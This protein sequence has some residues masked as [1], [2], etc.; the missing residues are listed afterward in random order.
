MAKNRTQA[1]SIS[2]LVKKSTIKF[3]LFNDLPS[4]GKGLIMVYNSHF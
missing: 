3:M 2:T 1:I 4:Y